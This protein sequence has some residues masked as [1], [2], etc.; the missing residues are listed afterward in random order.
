LSTALPQSRRGDG[1]HATEVP[2]RVLLLIAGAWL[3][4]AILDGVQRYVRDSL[5][6]QSGLSWK[7]AV[8]QGAKWL[9]LSALT[10]ITYYMAKR[11]PIRRVDWGHAI[12]SHV[13]GVIALTLGWALIGMVVER[14]LFGTAHSPRSWSSEYGHWLLNVGTSAVVMYFTMLAGFQAFIYYAEARERETH[15]SRLA[16]Q[17]AEARLQA[18]R[19][20]LN[21]HFLFNSLNAITVLVR[22]KN[23]RAAA[24][25]LELLSGLLRQVL[26]T[27]QPHEVALSEELEFVQRYLAIE[28]VRFADRLHVNFDIENETRDALVP[29]F[30]LQPLVENAIRHGVARRED[31]GQIS[32]SSR[33]TGA[34]LHLSVRD[35][36]MGFDPQSK[37][38][39]VG[40]SNTRERL[41]T[42]YGDRANLTIDTRPNHGTDVSIVLPYRPANL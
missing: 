29:T 11:Y 38:N 28:Q 20:Q 34:E 24:R 2:P 27:E 9:A 35:D 7:A 1:Q 42:L 17:L 14:G 12:A 30:L 33:M 25:V 4:P 6:N 15:A 10:P 19:G 16:E 39:G 18:L 13:V 40:L 36:G 22:D 5:D 41:R 31:A 23:N 37:H 26:R 21:P 3:V 8:F 32:I